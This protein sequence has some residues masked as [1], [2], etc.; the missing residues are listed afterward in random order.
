[1]ATVQHSTP[2]VHS[3]PFRPELVLLKIALQT[4]GYHHHAVAEIV[5]HVAREGTIEGAPGLEPDDYETAESILEPGCEPVPMTSHEWGSP[6]G[7][8]SMWPMDD[9]WELGGDEPT[10][11]DRLDLDQWLA[12]IDNVNPPDDQAEEVRQ[13]YDSRSSFS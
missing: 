8:G 5:A 2:G 4:A 9:R 6:T 13:W 7:D 10:A 11:A 12:Q 1:M 3:H